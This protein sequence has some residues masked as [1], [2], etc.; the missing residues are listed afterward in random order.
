[1]ELSVIEIIKSLG[2]PGVIFVIWYFDSRKIQNLQRVIEEQVADKELMREDR[3]QLIQMV[4]EISTLISRNTEQ[5]E[6]VERL[7]LK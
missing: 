4:R 1:M 5:A 6:R 7:L 2:L 3:Q